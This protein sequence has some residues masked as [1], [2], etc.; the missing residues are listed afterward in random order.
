[1]HENKFIN[2]TLS[3]F[4]ELARY[5]FSFDS[6]EKCDCSDFVKSEENFAYPH[7]ISAKNK[8]IVILSLLPEFLYSVADRASPVQNA[9]CLR[10][11]TPPWTLL[12][13]MIER[14]INGT[15]S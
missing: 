11:N 3:Y 15:L 6:E 5:K 4:P 14:K 9:S 10:R 2:R 13:S 12:T 7:Y 1:M 8:T